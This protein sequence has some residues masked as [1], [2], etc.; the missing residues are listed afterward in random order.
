MFETWLVHMISYVVI[1][2]ILFLEGGYFYFFGISL[3]LT[4]KI[5]KE[6]RIIKMIKKGRKRKDKKL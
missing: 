1:L 5:W 6:G 3:F 2:D 4:T